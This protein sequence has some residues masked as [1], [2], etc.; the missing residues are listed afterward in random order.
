MKEKEEEEE[1]HIFFI[2]RQA[3]HVSR[4][5]RTAFSSTTEIE[6]ERKT[7]FFSS[8]SLN[9]RQYLFVIVQNSNNNHNQSIGY[10][11]IILLQDYF[12]VDIKYYF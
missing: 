8:L 9:C 7:I 10:E 12:F 3:A 4:T 1:E 6:K 11:L 2:I 5:Y